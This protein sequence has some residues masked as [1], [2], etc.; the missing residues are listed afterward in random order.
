MINLA[1]ELAQPEI[2][3]DVIII[4]GGVAG[5]AFADR[6]RRDAVVIESGGDAPDP[7][8]DRLFA[9]ESAGMP[10]NV[11]SLQRRLLG[12][13]GALWSARCAELDSIDFD[14]REGLPH[15]GWPITLSDLRL[16]F[17]AVATDWR[18]PLAASKSALDT[19]RM[20][21]MFD[22]APG[23]SLQLWNY[24]F[25]R[26]ETPL[27]LG[28]HYRR[29]FDRPGK[30]LLMQADATGMETDGRQVIAVHVR[31]R[32]GKVIRIK[33]RHIVLAGGCV[34][35][36]RFL[37]EH[38]ARGI[39]LCAEVH[40]W[41]GRGFHQHLVVNS[42][43]VV[44]Q[45]GT[46]ARLQHVFNRKRRRPAISYE[47]GVRPSDALLIQE[48]LPNCSA[49][50]LYQ[51]T[52]GVTASSVP[53]LAINWLR[54]R[55]PILQRPR[56][57]VEIMAEQQINPDSSI[58]LAPDVDGSGRLGA[59]VNWK[60]GDAEKQSVVRLTNLLAG[61]LKKNGLGE[62]AEISSHDQVDFMPMR[63]S[64]HHMGGTRMSDGPR[65]G[66]V[67]RNLLVHGTTNVTVLGGSV[68]PTGG[69]ANPTLTIAALAL[70]A[71]DHLD[72]QVNVRLAG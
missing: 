42:G 5:L 57:L 69:H 67:D 59:R 35:N 16:Y 50:F 64:L 21:K 47:V 68:F 4:G 39:Q 49:K 53:S 12:G 8:R 41:L 70:R 14:A 65:Y 36:S 56:I 7:E 10:M 13:S 6:L 17:D 60:V 38:Q 29:V 54:G 63:D 43:S 46:G 31:D 23:L 3:T 71:A 37:L 62:L 22:T 9:I 26:R 58:A 20:R 1:H 33:G 15:S 32:S 52:G 2:E 40:R 44:A 11:Q 45:N 18:L 34:E 48:S 28:R 66:V 19:P 55:E 25:E 24:A 61:F 30:R 27:N 51:R 72:G